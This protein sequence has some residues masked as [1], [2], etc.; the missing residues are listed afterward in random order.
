[1]CSHSSTGDADI[2]DRLTDQGGEQEGEGD[3]NG[4]SS[5]GARTPTFVNI[6]P[7]GICC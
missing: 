2:V 5:M 1:M 6:Q 4:E 3:M 7:V